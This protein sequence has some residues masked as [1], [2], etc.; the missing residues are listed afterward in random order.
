VLQTLDEELQ[1]KTRLQQL[2]QLQIE[3]RKLVDQQ[4]KQQTRFQF[5]VE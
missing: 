5:V 1:P 2:Q 4:W 3:T